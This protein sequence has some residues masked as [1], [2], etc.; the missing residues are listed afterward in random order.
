MSLSDKI[1][2]VFETPLEDWPDGWLKLEVAS[3]LD[4]PEYIM[5]HSHEK[6]A[7]ELPDTREEMIAFLRQKG[8]YR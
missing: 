5:L 8:E 7:K 6:K 4:K 1:K 2:K 3:Q